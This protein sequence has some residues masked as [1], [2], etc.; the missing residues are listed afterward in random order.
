MAASKSSTK[1]ASGAAKKTAPPA[2][3]KRPS[4]AKQRPA[5][6]T[7]DGTT[8]EMVCKACGILQDTPITELDAAAVK[9]ERA[10]CAFPKC[11]GALLQYPVENLNAVARGTLAPDDDGEKVRITGQQEDETEPAPRRRRR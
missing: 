1:A 3:W 10:S 7:S 5:R 9:G 8:R 4:R 2:A 6:K 11:G